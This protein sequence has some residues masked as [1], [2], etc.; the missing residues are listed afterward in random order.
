MLTNTDHN[1]TNWQCQGNQRSDPMAGAYELQMH[2]TSKPHTPCDRPGSS[3]MW[4]PGPCKATWPGPAAIRAFL[5]TLGYCRGC[6]ATQDG[7]LPRCATLTDAIRNR[8]SARQ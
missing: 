4:P 1:I 5:Q 3:L 7:P 2:S 6:F 8:G